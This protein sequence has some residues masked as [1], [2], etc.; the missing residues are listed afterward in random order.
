MNYYIN[1]DGEPIPMFTDLYGNPIEKTPYSHPYDF[2]QHVIWVSNKF[3][4]NKIYS[5][6]YS[7]RM[8][9]WDIEKFERCLQEV[10]GN[11]KQ[12]FDDRDP[13]DIEKFLIKYF[14]HKLKLVAIEKC[15][16]FPTGY[17]IWIFHFEDKSKSNK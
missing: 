1:A 16:Y 4:K 9:Q 12:Y 10:F 8:L 11:Q 3:D 17:P 2:D 7:D 5:A 6:E 13:K 15:C 14:G